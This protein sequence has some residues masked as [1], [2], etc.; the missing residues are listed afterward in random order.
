MRVQQGAET[1][2][3][4]GATLWGVLALAYPAGAAVIVVPDDNPSLRDAVEQAAP[5]DV[6]QVRPG[7]YATRV[8]IERGQTGL[9]IEGLGG[10]PVIQPGPLDD[11]IRI[12]EVDGV[13]VR[14]LEVQGG[15]RA[16]RVE[17][18]NGVLID[19][20]VGAANKE[21]VRAKD[22]AG[23]VVRNSALSGATRGRGIRV[24]RSSAPALLDNTVAG[25]RQEG[26]RVVGSPGAA[27]RGNTL[28]ANR[29]GG[30][31]VGKSAGAAVETN[32]ADGNGRSGIR[33][34][35]SPSTTVVD[36]NADDNAEYGIRVQ[37]S[38]PIATVGDLLGAG[39]TAS[40][41]GILDLRVD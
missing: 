37:K 31:R 24:E 38:P 18:A 16:V 27:V 34:A 40:G 9:T 29:G 39:N 32:S 33:I 41:N 12:R 7:T 25:S 22:T 35:V 28:T 2:F 36:N 15:Q 23:L 30:V 6:V 17:K 19:D 5:G 8:R 11:G 1:A 13:T 20:V 4:A 14:G 3:L 10:R 21:G 26:I